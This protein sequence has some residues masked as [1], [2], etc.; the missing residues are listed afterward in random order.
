M[1]T[2]WTNTPSWT[3]S[4]SSEQLSPE[5]KV[6][7]LFAKL[8]P[9]TPKEIEIAAIK[10]ALVFAT[11]EKEI[12]LLNSL[13]WLDKDWLP[14]DKSKTIF[15]RSLKPSQIF[16]FKKSVVE[17]IT[18]INDWKD[19]KITPII[20]DYLKKFNEDFQF[21]SLCWWFH[22]PSKLCPPIKNKKIDKLKKFT[23]KE[24]KENPKKCNIHWEYYW[25]ECPF[26][27]KEKYIKDINNFP[28]KIENRVPICDV[29]WW[30]H[31]TCKN[32]KDNL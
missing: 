15:D 20:K 16:R 2:P 30:P 11:D 8:W 1:N 4:E 22:N 13:I 7:K 21:C 23:P 10:W 18:K 3:V 24:K 26:C 17:M 31:K 5:K 9:N 28:K 32:P 12:K 27:V 29:C 14:L 25:T 6:E 19:L